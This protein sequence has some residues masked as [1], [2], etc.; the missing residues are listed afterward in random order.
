MVEINQDK[1]SHST[2]HELRDGARRDVEALV[3]FE[4]GVEGLAEDKAALLGSYIREDIHSAGTA[5]SE[6]KTELNFMERRAGEWL[7]SAADQTPIDWLWLD[8]CL[9]K[10]SGQL[11]ASE[12]V[13]DQ[14]L[15]CLNCGA[16]YKAKGLVTLSPC[17]QCGTR[18]FQEDI[19][20]H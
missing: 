17:D 12:T 3:E 13:C 9:H 10:D 19:N 20:R 5:F 11:M 6:L 18:F 16:S 4:L 15:H 2:L 8:L 1:E 7:L 14:A